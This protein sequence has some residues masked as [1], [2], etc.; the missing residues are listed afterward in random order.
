MFVQY[1]RGPQVGVGVALSCGLVQT[2]GNKQGFGAY[3]SP[4]KPDS[5]KSAQR[6]PIQHN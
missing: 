3:L 6:N 2:V 1:P 4:A 5:S